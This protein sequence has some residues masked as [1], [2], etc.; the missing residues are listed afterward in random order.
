MVVQY[1][2]NII[3][4]NIDNYRKKEKKGDFNPNKFQTIGSDPTK[5]LG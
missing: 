5:I 3:S 2:S 1:V 4:K